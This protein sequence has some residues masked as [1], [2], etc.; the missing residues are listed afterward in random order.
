MRERPALAGAYAERR[1]TAQ[2]EKAEPARQP[3]LA[4]QLQ[5]MLQNLGQTLGR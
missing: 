1:G 2:I 5:Q 4:R 3:D